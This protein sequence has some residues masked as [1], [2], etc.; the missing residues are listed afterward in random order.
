MEDNYITTML[1]GVPRA[2]SSLIRGYSVRGIMSHM[3]EDRVAP[4]SHAKF[5]VDS[6]QMIAEAMRMREI[7]SGERYEVG[8]RCSE[9]LHSGVP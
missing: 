7:A 6:V 9:L 4:T 3:L 1:V 2:E 8:K 5:G